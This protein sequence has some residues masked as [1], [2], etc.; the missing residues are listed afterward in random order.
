MKVLVIMSIFLLSGLV[1][2]LFS[3]PFTLQPLAPV[4]SAIVLFAPSNLIFYKDHNIILGIST[5]QSSSYINTNVVSFIK[6]L[7]QSFGDWQGTCM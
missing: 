1:P 4:M 5:P 6:I 7:N 3:P 2:L